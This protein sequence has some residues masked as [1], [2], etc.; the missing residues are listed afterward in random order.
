MRQARWNRP[1]LEITVLILD[2]SLLMSYEIRN[3]NW[4]IFCISGI[5][6]GITNEVGMFVDTKVGAG[7]KNPQAALLN[8]PG[9][10]LHRIKAAKNLTN[11]KSLIAFPND[12]AQSIRPSNPQEN[13]K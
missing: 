12:R 2:S 7:K 10:K 5:T 13:F 6:P 3:E 11:E 9:T 8:A 4:I 1:E